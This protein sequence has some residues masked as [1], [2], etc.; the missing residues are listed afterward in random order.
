MRD[1]EE[2]RDPSEEDLLI[3]EG[4]LGRTIEGGKLQFINLEMIDKR[5]DLGGM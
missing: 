5:E 4:E 2:H 3:K 1:T